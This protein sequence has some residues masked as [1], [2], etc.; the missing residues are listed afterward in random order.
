MWVLLWFIVVLAQELALGVVCV[1]VVHHVVRD[2]HLRARLY[3]LVRALIVAP[4]VQMIVQVGVIE[5]VRTL[6]KAHVQISA[7][8][9]VKDSAQPDVMEV[10]IPTAPERAEKH[11][12]DNAMVDV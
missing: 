2:A 1:D 7:T 3:V 9:I 5:R 6:V 12:R 8:K 10:V 11:V 4:L